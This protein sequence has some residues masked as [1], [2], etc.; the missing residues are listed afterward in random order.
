MYKISSFSY[1]SYVGILAGQIVRSWCAVLLKTDIR[2][3]V[4]VQEEAELEGTRYDRS[5]VRQRHRKQKGI[6]AIETAF[7]RSL[8]GQSL[9]KCRWKWYFGIRA[10][11]F[12][13]AVFNYYR[14]QCMNSPC[15]S[16]ETLSTFCI[17]L[18]RNK[19]QF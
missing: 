14:F 10:S 3:N 1:F 5:R 19:A 15:V 12:I 2:S 4:P 8:D 17:A 9:E 16:P 13:T 7:L 11:H 18:M 6:L